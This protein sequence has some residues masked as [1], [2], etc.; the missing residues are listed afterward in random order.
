MLRQA[1]R[2]TSVAKIVCERL[3]LASSKSEESRGSFLQLAQHTFQGAIA[4]EFS[5]QAVL[6]LVFLLSFVRPRLLI[7]YLEFVRSIQQ[8]ENS[9]L[10]IAGSRYSYLL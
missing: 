10:G 4:K 7:Q 8:L 9:T 1:D 2:R 5:Q 6:P 3:E